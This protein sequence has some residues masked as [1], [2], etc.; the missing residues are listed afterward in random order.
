MAAL[1]RLVD[2]SQ[3]RV[4]P[5]F[6]GPGFCSRRFACEYFRAFSRR[7]SGARATLAEVRAGPRILL[8]DEPSMGLASLV[9]TE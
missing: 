8:L 1:L 4:L 9:V 7:D 2:A 6:C 5:E 3:D